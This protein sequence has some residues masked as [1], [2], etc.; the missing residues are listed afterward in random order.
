M[1]PVAA[2]IHA[3]QTANGRRPSALQALAPDPGTSS[4]T[5]VYRASQGLVLLREFRMMGW[6]RV[7]RQLL[8]YLSAFFF[9]AEDGIRVLTVTGVQTCALPIWPHGEGSA[10]AGD[11]ALMFEPGRLD[12][13]LGAAVLHEHVGLEL[14]AVAQSLENLDGPQSR[15]EERRVGKECRSR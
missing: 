7:V 13:I 14:V 5:H 11:G 2:N 3:R 4:G 10:G 9:Q 15:S 8:F 1:F 6:R 12:G